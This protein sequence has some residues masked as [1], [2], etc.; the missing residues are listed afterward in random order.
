MSDKI[1]VC[2]DL[3]RTL[4]PNGKEPES[5]DARPLFNRFCRQA[6]VIL[7][8][9]S[10]RDRRLLLQA[11]EEYDIPIPDYAI[12]DVGT[13]IYH[14]EQNQWRLDDSWS[15]LQEMDWRGNSREALQG[16]L[17]P[18]SG[19]ILQEQ[20]KQNTYKLSYYLPLDCDAKEVIRQMQSILDAEHINANIIW[21]ID[22]P[23]NIGLIDVLPRAA[24]KLEAIRFLNRK[25]AIPL[26][27]T[28][29]SGDSG[30]DLSVLTSE[31]P[32]VL[33]ANA[34]DEVRA[35]AVRL[36]AQHASSDQ[37]YLAHGT[38]PGLNGNYSAGILEGI[39]H[40]IADSRGWFADIT[41]NTSHSST[42]G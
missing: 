25:L 22:E 36:A 33:V 12:G 14:I 17:S 2:T 30:N 8:Y 16:M 21:S 3:D 41:G 35:E 1:L 9:V 38:L 39:Y 10:G 4:L 42:S 19:L 32:S 28:V 34:N 18:V 13:S 6:H 27:R 7:V 20:E 29:F 26:E 23:N 5:P 31:I 24:N 15:A 40:Y 37:L 11:I